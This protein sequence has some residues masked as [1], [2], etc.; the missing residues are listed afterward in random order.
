MANRYVD[1]LNAVLSTFTA[2][3]VTYPATGQGAKPVLQDGQKK[4]ID[5]LITG[6]TVSLTTTLAACGTILA[7][8]EAGKYASKNALKTDISKN[9]RLLSTQVK[10]LSALFSGFKH[11]EDAWIKQGGTL[12]WDARKAAVNEQRA[13][14]QALVKSIEEIEGNVK[15]DLDAALKS[16]AEGQ[17]PSPQPSPGPSPKPTQ[18]PAAADPSAQR[19]ALMNAALNGVPCVEIDPALM[20]A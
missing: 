7:T 20:A 5:T 2:T 19:E 17:K 3:T 16:W 8:V 13:N 12:S 4:K 6:D 1:L 11:E 18:S 15:D 9:E 10:S 14:N